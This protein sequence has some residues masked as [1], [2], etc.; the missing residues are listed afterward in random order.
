MFKAV[1]LVIL[2]TQK[3]TATVAKFSSQIIL[4]FAIIAA[5]FADPPATRQER[6]AVY[7]AYSPL[8]YSAYQPISAYSAYPYSYAAYPSVYSGYYGGVPAAVRYI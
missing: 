1:S 4:V 6:A 7:S 8:Q 3:N 5:V 2:L